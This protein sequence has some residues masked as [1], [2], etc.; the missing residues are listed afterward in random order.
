MPTLAPHFSHQPF[1]EAPP[2]CPNSL[3]HSAGTLRLNLPSTFT[4]SASTAFSLH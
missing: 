1:S 4:Q 2:E 3:L